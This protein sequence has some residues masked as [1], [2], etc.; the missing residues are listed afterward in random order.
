[1][2]S[3]F[4]LSTLLEL[5]SLHGLGWVS[6]A[7]FNHLCVLLYQAPMSPERNSWSFVA[8]FVKLCHSVYTEDGNGD[9]LRMGL[10]ELFVPSS[11]T[12]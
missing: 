12:L 7:R 2:N 9:A 11:N 5:L 10:N 8:G 6:G 4:F 1:M 3:F